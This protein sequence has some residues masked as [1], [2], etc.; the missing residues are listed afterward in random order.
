MDLTQKSLDLK[1]KVIDSL[2]VWADQRIDK[3]V[4]DNP[5]LKPMS[6][7]IKRGIN[8]L[9]AREDVKFADYIDNAMLFIADENG[10]YDTKM[11]FDDC[12]KMFKD[13]DEMPFSIGGIKG[14]VGKGIIRIPVPEN[15]FTSMVFGNM[16]AIKITDAD[17]I[18]LKTLIEE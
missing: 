18:E 9:I 1:C 7:Y 11:L 13:M 2:K 14:S 4:F 12:M 5:K 6:V 3:L 17:F 15:M 8:N 16:G 10:N